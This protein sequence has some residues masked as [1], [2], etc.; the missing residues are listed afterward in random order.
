MIQLWIAVFQALGNTLF[1]PIYDLKL[2]GAQRVT[3]HEMPQNLYRGWMCFVGVNSVIP[4]E[5]E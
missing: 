1:V 4:P 3:F 2:L 5:L